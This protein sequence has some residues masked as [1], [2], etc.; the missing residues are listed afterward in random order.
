MALPPDRP[1]FT[2]LATPSDHKA[3]KR[4][5]DMDTSTST[6][7]DAGLQKRGPSGAVI[8]ALVAP[9]A[10]SLFRRKTLSAVLLLL[11]FVIPIATVV[12]ALVRRNE[13]TS[14]VLNENF[15]F[16]LQTVAVLFVLSRM[17]SVIEVIRS[18]SEGSPR[19]LASTLAIVG[20]MLVATP[21][22]WS[23]AR[24]QDLSD[25][26]SDVFVS[27]GSDAPLAATGDG[28]T[29]SAGFKTIL[30]LGGD[31]GPGRWAL[32]TDTMILV[33][34]HEESGRM[35]MISIPR[36]MY[37]MKFPPGSA[38]A[39][40][41]PQGFPELAN[42]IYPYVFTHEDISA[43]YVRGDLQPEA[44]ALASAISYSMEITIDDYVLVN[45][46]GFLE[47]IDALGGVTLTLDK[48]LPM[49]GNIPGAKHPYP[50]S[51]GPGEVTMDGTTALGFA[52][53]RSGDSDYGRMG[54]Q[55][56]LL[57]AIASQVEGSDILLR[58]PNLTEI[59]RWTVRTS[60]SAGEFSSLVDRLRS[61]ASV[62]E[63]I[64][65]VPPLINP[66][67]PNFT[68]ITNLIDALQASIR[69]D[70]DFPYA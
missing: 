38:M 66:G 17:I 3:L 46:Q 6:P 43:T 34:I 9:G 39:N 56:Q 15:L 68:D 60:L 28:S 47:I 62:K 29:S 49:P 52:R 31:E 53:S 65:L 10:P 24:A 1:D 2:D 4:L 8:G 45:M 35:A 50:D 51:V 25:V 41:F 58:F 64:G 69:D 70:V 67:N 16:G 59:M 48:E 57:T 13:I 19:G 26:I 5:A 42:A 37:K 55:R 7:S 18:R 23:I 20:V 63:S 32:R 40:E 27:S 22:V 14:L 54:R 21:A 61:G 30:L 36:N 11:G 12:V 44:L 33:T